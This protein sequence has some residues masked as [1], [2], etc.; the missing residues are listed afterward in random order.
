M[1]DKFLDLAMEMVKAQ[2]A[3]K[4]MSPLEI[5]QMTKEIADG[6]RGIGEPQAK[7]ELV[8]APKPQKPAVDPGKSIRA[9][10]VICI[11]CG[12]EFGTLTKVHLATH[13]L[14]PDEY[15][16]KWN[17]GR[18]RPLVAGKLLEQ[19]KAKMQEMR[20]WERR[21]KAKDASA[22]PAAPVEKKPRGRKPKAE[23]ADEAYITE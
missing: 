13:G 21:G 10:K 1:Q 6:L 20:L 8:E 15:R 17:L 19:R 16:Q 7:A 9:D 4:P 14:T 22:T 18:G 3:I 23:A 5:V 2:A 11:E 12:Q